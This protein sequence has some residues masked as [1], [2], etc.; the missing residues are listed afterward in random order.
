MR[1]SLFFFFLLCSVFAEGQVYHLPVDQLSQIRQNRAHISTQGSVHSGAKPIL[2]S[3][4]DVTNIRPYAEDTV[5][6]YF[7]IIE[8]LFSTHLI[9]LDKPDFK[10]YADFLLDFG[11]GRETVDQI[12]RDGEDNTLFQNTRGFALQGQIG[13][14]VF[15]YTDFRENQGRYPAYLTGYVDSTDVFPG[16]GRIKPFGEGGFDYSMASGYIGVRANDWLNLSLGHSRQFLG[17]GHRSLLLSDVSHNFPFAS[18]EVDVL[19]KKVQYRYTL[20][21][22]QNLQRLPQGETPEAIFKRKVASW[23]YLS[24][25]PFPNLEIGLF[26]EVLW[27]V[28]DDSLGSQPFQY[29]AL[30]PVPFLNSAIL[31]L[32]DEEN[33]ARVGLNLAW[34]PI[35]P[36]KVY[37]QLLST[38]KGLD[39]NGYQLGGIYSGLF[40]RF[41]VQLEY[42]AMD[43][44]ATLEP[45]KLQSEYHFNQPLGHILG[46]NF[47]EWTGRVTYLHNRVFASASFMMAEFNDGPRN[48]FHASNSEV[49]NTDL[50]LGYV[51]NPSSNLQLYGGY[52][53]RNEKERD[54]S[55]SNGFWYFGI[56]TSLS[57]IYRDF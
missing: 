46:R 51:F 20:A 45:S 34:N 9:E 31:G 32:D 29:Q 11:Y 41:D 10:L 39:I 42:N 13:D 53:Y 5:D 36:L 18:Y 49:S 6:Y 24:Y 4:A 56:K 44:D 12:S 28:F 22:L 21:L 14:R 37:G 43:G 19:E 7:K 50:R 48:V 3:D 54:L 52:T 47:Q 57:N 35:N 8:K 30:V 25:K 15:F 26:E 40:K 1:V 27:N 38:N 33:N 17:H 16:S 23:N 2:V 55:H